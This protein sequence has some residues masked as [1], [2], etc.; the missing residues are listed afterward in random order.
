MGAGRPKQFL[1]LGGAPIL[2][3]TAR[4][5][6]ATARLE[7][8][9]VVVPA[10]RVARTRALLRRHAVARVRAIVG[11]GEE[12][13]ESVALGLQAVPPGAGWVVV[14]DGVRPFVS[15]DLVGRV[16]AAARATGAAAAGLPV[17]ETVKRVRG[18]FVESTLDR[19]GLWLVQTPQAFRRELLLEA[20]DKA[21]REGYRGTDDAQLV[22]RL[23]VRVAMVPGLPENLK[24][25]TRADLERARR[26]LGR[27]E[28]VRGRR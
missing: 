27:H 17:R 6:V 8:L 12:R 9:V 23:G 22:E 20:H 19:E 7:G 24:I 13:Q 11:G 25:T 21:R 28:P 18:G 3:R 5:L 4:R 14:H 2:V 15:A 26:W 16:L 1:A 10:S